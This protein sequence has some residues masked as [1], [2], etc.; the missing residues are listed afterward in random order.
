[1]KTEDYFKP[2]CFLEKQNRVALTLISTNNYT[3]QAQDILNRKGVVKILDLYNKNIRDQMRVA[4]L[5]YYRK[6]DYISKYK[7]LDKDT[8]LVE[9]ATT[10]KD[11]KKQTHQYYIRAVKVSKDFKI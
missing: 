11:N 3:K 6:I 2:M 1:M 8:M 7:I 4:F 10:S 9:V 5:K